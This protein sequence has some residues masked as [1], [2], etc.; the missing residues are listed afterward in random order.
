M[1]YGEKM[2]ANP[3]NQTMKA[4]SKIADRLKEGYNK[5][6]IECVQ[7]E[8]DFFMNK[9]KQHSRI[10]DGGCG[11]GTHSLYFKDKGYNT[12]S[13]DL[14]PRMVEIC[15]GRGLDAL[16]MDLENLHF[17]DNS[18]DGVWC[19]TSLIHFDSKEKISLV[20]EK[21]NRI[22]KPDSSLFV[23]LREGNG[24]KWELYHDTPDTERWFLYFK[25]GEFEK[26]I[27]PTFIVDRIGKT[28]YKNHRFL[29]YHLLLKK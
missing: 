8:A 12:V 26:Y 10:L 11:V 2:S 16:V 24:E 19:H 17:A 27:P 15:R 9:L 20:L 7:Q 28:Q 3:K 5:Y 14:N 21:I 22:L 23:A 18:F 29:N 1:S 25:Q 13:V 4:Y 6:F